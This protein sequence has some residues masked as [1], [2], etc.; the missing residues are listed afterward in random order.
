MCVQPSVARCTLV[1]CHLLCGDCGPVHRPLS[2]SGHLSSKCAI[3]HHLANS[4][5][6][7]QLNSSRFLCASLFTKDLSCACIAPLLYGSVRSSPVHLISRSPF[8]LSQ[9]SCSSLGAFHSLSSPFDFVVIALCL[10]TSLTF[11]HVLSFMVWRGCK[12]L[13]L[14]VTSTSM[15]NIELASR[16]K[17]D[18]LR[19]I[20][21]AIHKD[22]GP[23]RIQTFYILHRA[24][25]KQICVM[26]GCF[27]PETF[28]VLDQTGTWGL[29]KFE[30]GQCS[31]SL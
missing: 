27:R 4:S 13:Q 12:K 28:R 22:P 24:P 15:N 30:R 26:P 7:L 17:E 21:G 6:S 29:S 16:V 14:Q 2:P 31:P 1:E 10:H 11:C 3:L 23:S 20:I 18:V 19:I 8:H 9:S 5:S 25:L